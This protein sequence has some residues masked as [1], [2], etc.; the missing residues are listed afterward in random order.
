MKKILMAVVITCMTGGIYAEVNNP[1]AGVSSK[2]IE[3]VTIPGGIFMMG[4]KD[5]ARTAYGDLLED[6]R[7]VHEVVIQTFDMS[8][9]AVTVEQYA[10]CVN[11][12]RCTEP[13]TGGSP[14][15]FGAFCNW[16]KP[17]RQNHPVNCVDWDQAHQYAVFAG[18]RLPSEAEWEYAAR[19]GGRDRKY[20]WG[21]D[22]PSCEKAVMRD[23]GEGTMPV[24]SRPAGNTIH[25]LC[26]MAGNAAQWLQDK[27]GDY[28]D[29]PADG[30]AHEGFS[31]SNGRV[32]RG[33]SFNMDGVFL[34]AD[35]R[36]N[37]SPSG[38]FSSVGFRLAR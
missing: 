5:H 36:T 34:R 16:G 8:R 4:T 13:A 7:P 33:G 3:W 12:G 31:P 20:P 23:C 27:Y 15:G 24:C 29:T 32:N 22:E 37:D 14:G 38:R 17:G 28:K 11:K 35:Y 10:E 30:S 25:G 18:A 2:P 9:T 1:R 19:S 26:D 21:N 6:A